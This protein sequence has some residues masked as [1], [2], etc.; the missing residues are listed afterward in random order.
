MLGMVGSPMSEVG[1]FL[2]R[3]EHKVRKGLNPGTRNPKLENPKLTESKTFY[4]P[5]QK[6]TVERR[7]RVI[8]QGTAARVVLIDCQLVR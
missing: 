6:S 8:P 2:S 5:W 4:S 1:E 3:K 7:S